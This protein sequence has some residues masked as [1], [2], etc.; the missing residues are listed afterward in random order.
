[1]IYIILIVISFIAGFILRGYII[2]KN[3]NITLH[4]HTADVDRF[5]KESKELKSKINFLRKRN[6]ILETRISSLIFLIRKYTEKEKSR[7]KTGTTEN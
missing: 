4:N 7:L 6:K 1:M 3:H 2:D 5:L